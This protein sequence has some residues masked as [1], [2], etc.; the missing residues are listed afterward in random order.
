[1]MAT[2][3]VAISYHIDPTK[4]PFLYQHYRLDSDGLI[5][6]PIRNNVRNYLNRNASAYSIEEIYGAKKT[7]LI[8]KTQTDVQKVLDPLGIIVEQVYWAGGPRIPQQITDQINK[9]MANEQAAQA[10]QASVA[11]S[12]AEAE[13]KVA[14]AKGDAQATQIEGEAIRANPQILQQQWIQKWDGK[15]PEYV[16]GPDNKL[17]LNLPAKN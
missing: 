13:S 14:K 9:K 8:T 3:D 7:E 6:G 10:A 1:M 17:L 15:L 4:A 2:A 5:D 16:S 11:T 12:T